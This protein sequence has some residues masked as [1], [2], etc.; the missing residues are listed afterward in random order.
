MNKKK[1]AEW[2]SGSGKYWLELYQD[3]W[4]FTYKTDNGG[5]SIGGDL[6]DAI[7]RMQTELATWPV[8]AYRWI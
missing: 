8:V 4:G 1:I 7:A 5:G 2:R 3:Q 6:Q